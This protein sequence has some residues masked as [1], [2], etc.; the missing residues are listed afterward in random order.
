MTVALCGHVEK[1]PFSA[2]QDGIEAFRNIVVLE[3]RRAKQQ[4]AR[5]VS[6]QGVRGGLLILGAAGLAFAIHLAF[7]WVTVALYQRGWSIGPL[8]LAILGF[9]ILFA[10]LCYAIGKSIVRHASIKSIV[11]T[12]YEYH[13]EDRERAGSRKGAA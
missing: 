3:Q 13:R 1:I 10:G 5:V 12:V 11:R 4:A 8:V 9:G 2:I 7:F 6:R